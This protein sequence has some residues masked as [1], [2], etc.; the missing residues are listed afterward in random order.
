MHLGLDPAVV[1]HPDGYR[2]G[3]QALI[4][5]FTNGRTIGV[6]MLQWLGLTLDAKRAA[7]SGGAPYPA[8]IKWLCTE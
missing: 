2:G 3:S 1:F 6:P 8:M 4:E 7:E 5:N